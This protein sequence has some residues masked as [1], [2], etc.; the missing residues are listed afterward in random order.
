VP[1][2]QDLLERFPMEYRHL[3]Y[4][5]TKAGFTVKTDMPLLRGE[6]V[7]RLYACGAAWLGGGDHGWTG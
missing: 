4:V 1:L 7:Q 6:K 3:A 2:E 5:Q